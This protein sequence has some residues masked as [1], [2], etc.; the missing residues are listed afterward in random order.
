M[1]EKI[2]SIQADNPHFLELLKFEKLPVDDLIKHNARYY[3]VFEDDRLVAAA[4]IEFYFDSALLRSMVVHPDHRE[5]G[6]GKALLE[7]GIGMSLSFDKEH[8]YLLTES[9]ESYFAKLGFEVI[10]REKAPYSM[11]VSS[12][13]NGVCPETAQLMYQYIVPWLGS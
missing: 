2:K 9:T 11:K 10:E 4:G 1:I 3:G 12:Q 8:L 5:K 13:F 6:Y 7:Y